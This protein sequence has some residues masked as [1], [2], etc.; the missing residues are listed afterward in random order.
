M[1]FVTLPI[2]GPLAFIPA[3]TWEWLVRHHLETVAVVF[4]MIPA[5]LG[6][7]SGVI[8]RILGS[9][10]ARF[11][12]EISYGV[13]LWHLP[14]LAIIHERLGLPLFQGQFWRYY[15]LCAGSATV[16][17]T[18]SW[19]YVERPLLRRLGGR[20]TSGSPV[21]LRADTNKTAVATVP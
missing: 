5:T 14:M 11:A 15:L 18:L 8:A 4:M 19:F 17:G 10:V 16:L 2:G 20:S 3:S 21:T 1:W 13:Y 9:R 7:G 12:G 6:D